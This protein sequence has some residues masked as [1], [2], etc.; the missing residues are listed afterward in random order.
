MAAAAL[1]AE[2]DKSV[3][4]VDR[5]EGHG[6]Y[7]AKN[8]C[9][10]DFVEF[11]L[12]MKALFR[13]GDRQTILENLERCVNKRTE[14][15]KAFADIIAQKKD[16]AT[17]ED[18]AN[19]KSHETVRDMFNA[20]RELVRTIDARHI[21]NYRFVYRD[22]GAVGP[23][24]ELI[25]SPIKAEH[26]FVKAAKPETDETGFT[27]VKTKAAPAKAAPATAAPA[28]GGPAGQFSALAGDSK[29]YTDAKKKYD[30][31]LKVYEAKLEKWEESEEQREKDWNS[32]YK[33]VPKGNDKKLD[34]FVKKHGA[35]FDPNRGAPT[36][37]EEPKRE[38]YEGG[39]RRTRRKN[40]RR[41][42]QKKR[43]T[44]V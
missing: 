32:K 6:A 26:M 29:E 13:D 14:R 39:R 17:A 40:G 38:D 21:S 25:P 37:P 10:K 20:L 2:V 33:Q 7:H 12:D 27:M 18:I 34:E 5:R 36:P 42:T 4:G 43:K 22:G 35:E 16:G 8:A 3:A 30:K 9:N 28:K 19:Q 15:I 24:I 44:Y 23:T 31:E 11:V 41:R 1:D